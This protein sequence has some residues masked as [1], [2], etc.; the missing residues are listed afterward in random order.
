M[1]IEKMLFEMLDAK[2]LENISNRIRDEIINYNQKK[3]LSTR[4]IIKNLIEAIEEMGLPHNMEESLKT[5]VKKDFGEQEVKKSEDIPEVPS[6]ILGDVVNIMS[7]NL[8]LVNLRL[9]RLTEE[10]SRVDRQ[11]NYL[12][13]KLNLDIK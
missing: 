5:R 10:F 1:N 4:A 6:A 12:F 13:K 9:K 7:E 3:G 8:K 11:I 2:S